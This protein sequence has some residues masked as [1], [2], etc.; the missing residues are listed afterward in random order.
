MLTEPLELL[1]FE[2][3]KKVELRIDHGWFDQAL[4]H[5]AR[6]PGGIVEP[7]LRLFVLPG[8]KA[9][10]PYYWDVTSKRLMAMLRP[11]LSRPD[12]KELT[13]VVTPA[14]SA[15]NTHYTLEVT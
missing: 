9:F 15:P 3:G 2:D 5:P 11:Y 14:G 1:E 4:I 10:E 6:A 13:F 12:L 7:A 8:T